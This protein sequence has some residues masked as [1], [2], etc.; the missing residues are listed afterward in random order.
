MSRNRIPTG[1]ED[2][3]TFRCKRC[4]F[5]CN[6]DRDKTGSGSGITL[7]AITIAGKSLYDPIVHSGCPNCGCRNY[8]D[9]QK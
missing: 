8:Q 1:N 2:T 4:G 6:T 5:L 9:W 7:S 3:T